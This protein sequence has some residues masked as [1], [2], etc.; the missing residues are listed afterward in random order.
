MRAP[1][2]LEGLAGLGEGEEMSPV[3][4]FP[5]QVAERGAAGPPRG[6]ECRA[7]LCGPAGG[8]PVVAACGAFL[9]V[10]VDV[11]PPAGD[12]SVVLQPQQ[13]RVGRPGQQPGLLGQ[14]QAVQLAGGVFQQGLQDEEGLHGHP[15]SHE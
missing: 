2:L 8:Q 11:L 6:R 15:G 12:P 1:R 7:G 9:D 10:R 4:A 14:F 5:G 3:S 13:D